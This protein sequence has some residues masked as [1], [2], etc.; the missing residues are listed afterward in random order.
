MMSTSESG[1]QQVLLDAIK[2]LERNMD[3]KMAAMKR[4]LA[5]ER[6]EGNDKLVKR[7]K[8]KKLPTFK[9]K[10]HEAQYRFNEDLASNFGAVKSAVEEAPPSIAK[11]IA[12]VEEGEKLIADRNKLIRIADRSEHEW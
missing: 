8:L 2:Q 7:M 5:Q 11:V 10:C 1:S 12:A 9:T 4:E 6:E 3:D